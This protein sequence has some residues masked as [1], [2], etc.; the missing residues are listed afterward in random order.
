MGFQHKI[1]TGLLVWCTLVYGARADELRFDRVDEWLGWS[2]PSSLFID[3]EGTLRPVFIRQNINAIEN[4]QL[5][6]GGLRDAGSNEV[7]GHWAID[8]DRRTGWRPG[9]TARSADRW[10]ELDLGR[11]VSARAVRLHFAPDN[12]PFEIFDVLLSTGEQQLDQ[13]GIPRP[14]TAVYR[15]RTRIKGNGRHTVALVLD[16]SRQEP[17][18]L[19]RI[20]VLQAPAGAQLVEVEVEAVGDNLAVGLPQRGGG[21]EVV[22]ERDGSV[23]NALPL[24]EALRLVD[25]DLNTRWQRIRDIDG[26]K[27]VLAH[28]TLDLGAVYWLD[29]VRLISRVIPPRGF[30]FGFYQVLTSDGSQAPDGSLLWRRHFAG[31]SSPLNRLLGMAGHPLNRTPTRYVRIGWKFW[32]GA[33]AAARGGTISIPFCAFIGVTE[34]VQVFGAGYPR[35]VRLTSPFFDL[36][37]DKMIQAIEWSGNAP[38]GTRLEIRSRSGGGLARQIVHRDRNGREIGKKKWEKL[39]PHFRGPV[40]TLNSAGADWSPWSRPTGLAEQIS[41]PSA[42]GRYLQLEVRFISED[43]QVSAWLD[44]LN[45]KFGDLL[46]DGARAEVYPN[47]VVSGRDT[48]FTYF[49]RTEGDV[50]KAGF[51]RILL[52]GV[53]GMIFTALR[54]DGRQIPVQ[55]RDSEQGFEIV[56]DEKYYR[57]LLEID[58]RGTLFRQARFEASLA[59]SENGQVIRQAVVPGNAVESVQSEQTVVAVELTQPLIGAVELS[60]SVFTPNG[61]GA[62]DILRIGFNV[63]Q[64]TAP[65]PVRVDVFDL[66]GRRVRSLMQKSLGVGRIEVEWDGRDASARL[67]RPGSYAVRIGVEG[68][69]RSA[70]RIRL[71]AIAY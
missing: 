69:A 49:L 56:L 66:A 54:V 39:T 28:I 45:I 16:P 62:N 58:F 24:G 64:F 44:A 55:V 11:A 12:P 5:F 17:V 48:S 8:G 52:R 70:T 57:A 47:R 25:G 7:D 13:V 53:D 61:D 40:D 71:V 33:C 26:V 4:A 30:Q 2:I 19:V 51:D 35:Q 42:P 9:A 50:D 23:A 41:F 36:G 31:D 3:A 68:D 6:G 29:L 20:E 10:I 21:V 43:P 46:V 60:G 37:A 34:E 15:D 1:R 65:R 27:D 22:V 14:G 18:Q 67:L 32:D 63:L 59:D 38:A